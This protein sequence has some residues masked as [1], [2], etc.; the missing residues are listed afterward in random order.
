MPGEEPDM[1]AGR[2]RIS[3]GESE[4]ETVRDLPGLLKQ[5]AAGAEIVIERDHQPLAVV[6]APDMVPR[7]IS[8]SITLAELHEKQTGEAP[9]LDPNFAGPQQM[10]S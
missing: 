8:K 5:V 3:G 2:P 9:V 4:E 6:R 1:Y 7:T 10:G